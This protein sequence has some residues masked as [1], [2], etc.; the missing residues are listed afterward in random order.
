M[1]QDR[2]AQVEQQRADSRLQFPAQRAEELTV[3]VLFVDIQMRCRPCASCPQ[4]TQAGYPLTHNV[5]LSA[6]RLSRWLIATFAQK[7]RSLITTTNYL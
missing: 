2:A 1:P 7:R 6:R 3:T 5:I 4:T